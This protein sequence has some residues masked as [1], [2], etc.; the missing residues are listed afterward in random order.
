MREPKDCR[1]HMH[2]APS[3]STSHAE[4]STCS[5]RA[6]FT[7]WERVTAPGSIP[8][9]HTAIGAATPRAPTPWL[10]RRPPRS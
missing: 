2:E 6:K 5:F 9:N 10:W 1:A 8:P 7:A 3:S 4:N